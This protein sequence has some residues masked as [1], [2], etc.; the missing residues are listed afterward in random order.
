MAR[1]AVF[2][3]QFRGVFNP[4]EV[5]VGQRSHDFY[6]EREHSPFEDVRLDLR[7]TAQPIRPPIVFFTG[8][9]GSGKSSMLLRLLDHVA[10]DYFVVYFDIAHNLDSRKAN[11]IDL[12]YLLGATIYQVAEHEGVHPDP[13]NLQ[14][15]AES[16]YTVT[17]QT[18]DHEHGALNIAELV[19]GLVCFGASMLGAGLGEKL[20]AAVLKPVTFS[21]GVSEETARKR[22]IEPQVQNI[23]DNVNL[24]IADVETRYGKPVLVVVD[25]LDKL[26]RLEQ[27]RLIFL[28]SSVLTGPICRV[29]YTVP[30]LIAT[31]LAFGQVEE[32]SQ[33]YVLPNIKLYEKNK[34]AQRY[35][36]GYAMMREVVRRRLRALTLALDDIFEPDVLDLL[37]LKSGGIMRWLIGLVADASKAA[38]HA[39][40]DQLNR[41]AAQ[42][43]IANRAARLASRLTRETVDELR[44]VRAEKLPANTQASSELL[45]GL[46]IVAYRNRTTWYDAHPLIWEDLQER[47]SQ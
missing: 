13:R 11:Q 9:R 37:I 44:Q 6:Q 10:Q 16:V 35:E 27:A 12:L 32:E 31:S 8:H 42:Q 29:I 38:E 22:E 17:H 25:G 33:S 21:S 15:L 34:D 20:A 36:P 40:L 26:Q 28:E 18:K 30:M 47:H 45:H 5:L 19:K 24:I 43:A 23:I 46:L 7:I 41:T 1:P 39:G 2:W 4:E 14:E 3:D